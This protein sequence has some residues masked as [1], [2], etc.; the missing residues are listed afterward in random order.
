MTKFLDLF[1][2][3]KTIEERVRS[4]QQGDIDS[5][6]QLIQEYIPFITKALSNQVHKYIELENDDIF[7]IGLM[8]FN[9]AIDKYDEKKGSFLAF[10]SLVMKSRVID[11]W[12]KEHKASQRIRTIQLFSENR[13]EVQEDV[14][15][16]EGFESQVELKIDMA[17]LVER[18]KDFGVSLEDLIKSAPK[19]RDTKNTAIKIGRYVYEHQLLK[20]KFLRTQN[21]PITQIVK[22]LEVSKKVIQRN[23][24]FIIAVIFI[25]DSN[26]DTLK[27]YLS[28]DEGS[29]MDAT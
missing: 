28:I 9:E 14:A 26:L 15:V 24:K 20:E 27:H 12:R 8:A 11:Q 21:L 3:K 23:R 29:E 16:I 4:I 2:K 6:E 10:A 1:K 18:M 5:K 25:L 17:T 13:E 19:H 22:N 7:S